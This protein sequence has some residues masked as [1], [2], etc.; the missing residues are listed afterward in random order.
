VSQGSGES[1][2]VVGGAGFIGSHFVD[3]LLSDPSTGRVTI[4]DN[5]SSGREW[6]YAHHRSDRRFSVVRGDVKDLDAL[7]SAMDG[8]D[9]VIHLAS[10]PDIA[11]AATEPDIDFREGTYLTQNVVEAMRQT[12]TRRILYASGSGVYGD[13]GELEADEDHGPLAPISTYGASKLA[14]E[15]LITSYVHMFGLTGAIFRFGNVVGPRQTHG[16]GFDFLGR[17]LKDPSELQILGDGTQ[18]K[19]YIH[20]SDVVD[21]VLLTHRTSTKP[22]DVFNVATGDYITVREIAELACE[23]LGLGPSK[24]RLSFGTGN[25][26]WKGDVPVVRLSTARIRG[27]GWRC[28][29]TT[30]EALKASLMEMLPDLRAGRA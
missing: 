1:V 29:R 2:L 23:C 10:N 11:R 12:S 15:A 20:V 6:H 18:S 4:F 8:H 3:R 22:V 5:F 21:A 14:G 17:L 13:L 19:S 16:V 28:R 30:R 27:L 24:T 7:R 25:R 26:G 9:V